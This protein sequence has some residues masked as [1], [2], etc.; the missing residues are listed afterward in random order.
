MKDSLFSAAR[1]R[2]GTRDVPSECRVYLVYA[3]LLGALAVGLV[4]R[5]TVHEFGQTGLIRN[6]DLDEPALAVGIAVEERRVV[7]ECGV[8]LD[9]FAG[10]RTIDVT[11]GL[12]GFNLS[13]GITRVELKAGLLHF[14]VGH[15]GQLIDGEL[16]DAEGENISLKLVP[17][18]GFGVHAIVGGCHRSSR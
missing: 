4:V 5:R 3:E 8:R 14:H 13:E 10:D 1:P 12:D 6:L 15:V 16:G 11:C 2:R 18:V 7:G 9:D 17:F